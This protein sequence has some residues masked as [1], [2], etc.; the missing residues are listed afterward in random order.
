M[1]V[2]FHCKHCNYTYGDG[3]TVL[4]FGSA[5]KTHRAAKLKKGQ[6]SLEIRNA[7][8]HLTC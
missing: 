7:R 3:M 8:R 2:N 5:L 1:V 4:A 6:E